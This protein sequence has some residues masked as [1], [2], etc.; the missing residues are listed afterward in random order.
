MTLQQKEWLAAWDSATRILQ[1]LPSKT[2]EDRNFHVDAY[3]EE[4]HIMKRIWFQGATPEQVSGGR[5]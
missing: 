4:I 1:I 3:V 2:G 5:W